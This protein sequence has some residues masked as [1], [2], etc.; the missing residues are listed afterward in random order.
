LKSWSCCCRPP[1]RSCCSY[2]NQPLII[3][4]TTLLIAALFRPLRNLLQAI[5]DRRF[6]RSRYDAAQ[7]LTAFSAVLRQDVNLDEVRGHLLAAV[8]ETMRPAHAA[9]WLRADARDDR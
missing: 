1:S 4:P 6:Y 7:T 9:V 3:V 8:E 2:G 5:V